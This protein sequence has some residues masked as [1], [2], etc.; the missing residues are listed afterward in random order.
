MIRIGTR[1]DTPD[2][3]GKV[4]PHHGRKPAGK[5][6]LVFLDKAIGLYRQFYYSKEEVREV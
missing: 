3:R 4:V 5:D 2:G 6:Y 1:V